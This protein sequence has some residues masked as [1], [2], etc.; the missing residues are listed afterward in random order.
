VVVIRGASGQGKSALAYRYLHD[1]VPESWRFE[2]RL[3]QDRVH[4]LRI[5]R[6]LLGHLNAVGAPAYIC[7]NVEPRDANWLDLVQELAREPSAR[8]GDGVGGGLA[9]GTNLGS[10]DSVRRDRVTVRQ[11][12]SA[13]PVRAAGGENDASARAGIR[14]RLDPVRQRRFPISST[15]AVQ[16]A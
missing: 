6:A 15:L 8:A 3:I 5:A 2:I 9:P 16:A 10:V 7:V 13:G 1:Y 12:R 4:A 11:G 14:R